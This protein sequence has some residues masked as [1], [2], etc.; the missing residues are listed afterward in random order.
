MLPLIRSRAPYFDVCALDFK[1]CRDNLHRATPF[2]YQHGKSASFSKRRILNDLWQQGDRLPDQTGLI[3][4]RSP[5][6]KVIFRKYPLYFR[7]DARSV[8]GHAR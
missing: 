5:G 4:L 6:L 8:L 2:V 7:H 1:G 3:E